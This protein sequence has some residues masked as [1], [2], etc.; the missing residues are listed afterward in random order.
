MIGGKERIIMRLNYY[1]G[2]V[3]YLL[4]NIYNVLV[5]FND[6]KNILDIICENY[7]VFYI[8]IMFFM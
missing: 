4:G 5:L 3:R 2:L 8:F 6:F 7:W 1:D